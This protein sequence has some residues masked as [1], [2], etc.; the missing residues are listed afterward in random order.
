MISKKYESTRSE[1]FKTKKFRIKKRILKLIKKI[2][3]L[4]ALRKK[5]KQTLAT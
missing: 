5:S 2:F 1:L 4:K 3:L